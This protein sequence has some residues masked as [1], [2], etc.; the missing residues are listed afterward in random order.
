MFRDRR[1]DRAA[2]P[3]DAVEQVGLRDVVV[4]VVHD[5][6]LLVDDAPSSQRPRI[7]YYRSQPV[8][9]ESGTDRPTYACRM[10]E[11]VKPQ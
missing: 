10:V 8:R 2:N 4:G 11:N 5:L 9:V 1:L 6:G 7:R 3:D